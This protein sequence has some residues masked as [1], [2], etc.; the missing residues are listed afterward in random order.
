MR[1]YT[2]RSQGSLHPQYRAIRQL[3]Q[4]RAL[5]IRMK[6]CVS[7]PYSIYLYLY[8]KPWASQPS[9]KCFL[10]LIFFVHFLLEWVD[11][12]TILPSTGA[13]VL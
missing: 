9:L 1:T 7:S 4:P 3:S 11:E 8:Y 13:T 10:R 6:F 2:P 5:V 12:I